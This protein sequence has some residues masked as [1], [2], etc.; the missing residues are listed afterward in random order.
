MII[1]LSLFY[2][3]FIPAFHPTPPPGSPFLLEMPF[4]NNLLQ[5]SFNWREKESGMDPEK[6]IKS[7]YKKIQLKM[8]SWVLALT[9]EGGERVGCCWTQTA[10]AAVGWVAIPRSSC[11]CL[12]ALA[13]GCHDKLCS[14]PVALHISEGL[15]SGDHLSWLQSGLPPCS[16]KFWFL[17]SGQAG[18]CVGPAGSWAEGWGLCG[19]AVKE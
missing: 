17:F 12:G 4:L 16:L 11:S 3:V 8:Q 14:S 10:R 13:K 2:W 19:F 7:Y 5:P 15:A 18:S 9:L 1:C 6:C